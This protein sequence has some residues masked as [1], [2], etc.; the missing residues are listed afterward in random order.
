MVALRDADTKTIATPCNTNAG[1]SSVLYNVNLYR[2]TMPIATK[3]S[4]RLLICGGVAGME[5]IA[6]HCRALQAMRPAVRFRETN[7]RHRDIMLVSIHR[8]V[9]QVR[10]PIAI[11]NITNTGTKHIAT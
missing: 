3:Y 1:P 4:I 9:T 6:T 5:P 7:G 8:F 10:K 2:N 11:Q